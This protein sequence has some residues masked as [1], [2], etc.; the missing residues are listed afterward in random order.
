MDS[1]R[2]IQTEIHQLFKLVPYPPRS[3]QD[4]LR[5]LTLDILLGGFGDEVP[6][7][8]PQRVGGGGALLEVEGARPVRGAGR[9]AVAHGGQAAEYFG[10][11]ENIRC[12][13]RVY[14]L[15]P[16][17]VVSSLVTGETTNSQSTFYY[18]DTNCRLR[19]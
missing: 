7:G 11:L 9:E 13:Q 16:K 12:D 1:S 3:Q 8:V 6:H 15:N 17:S 14:S 5:R 19:E 2:T 10:A 4:R 18:T